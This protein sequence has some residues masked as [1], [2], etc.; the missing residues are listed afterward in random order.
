MNI[1][2]LFEKIQDEYLPE[3]LNG[4]FTLAG[5]LIVWSYDLDENSEDISVDDEDDEDYGFSFDAE[6]PEELLL[7]AYREDLELLE[8]LLDEI[9]ES[10]NWTVSEPETI[11]NLITFKLF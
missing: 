9:E 4:E 2:E 6:S 5:N 10:E 3:D 7:E 11:D 8:T 1:N